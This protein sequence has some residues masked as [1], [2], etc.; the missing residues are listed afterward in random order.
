MKVNMQYGL[1]LSKMN[2]TMN[3]HQIENIIWN[4]SH[5]TLSMGKVCQSSNQRNR[6]D[7]KSFAIADVRVCFTRSLIIHSHL[8]I[9][10]IFFAYNPPLPRFVFQELDFDI[11]ILALLSI[12]FPAWFWRSEISQSH[13]LNS[14]IIVPCLTHNAIRSEKKN[15]ER[16]I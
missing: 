13:Q 8:L 2:A 10:V 6:F 4:C 15:Y 12:P 1:Y 7:H 9:T 11:L 14:A 16:W 5:S 3:I